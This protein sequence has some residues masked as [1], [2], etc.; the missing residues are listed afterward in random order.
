MS[1]FIYFLD[2]MLGALIGYGVLAFVH[3]LK[4]SREY[5]ELQ[6]LKDRVRE[7]L[8]KLHLDIEGFKQNAQ[9]KIEG[10]SK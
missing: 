3:W 8:S 9:T 10:L 1:D 2:F 5:L 6:Q 4:L 7:E